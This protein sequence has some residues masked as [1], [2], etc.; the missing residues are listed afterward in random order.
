MEREKEET[1]RIY[2]AYESGPSKRRLTGE[3]ERGGLEMSSSYV[4]G[5]RINRTY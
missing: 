5:D 4:L 2:K 3:M 1:E